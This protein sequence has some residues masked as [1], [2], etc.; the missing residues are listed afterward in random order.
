ML[1]AN[2]LGDVHLLSGRSAGRTQKKVEA[3]EGDSMDD[4]LK[5]YLDQMS[6]KISASMEQ[7]ESRIMSALR[8]FGA[9][10]DAVPAK[11]EG[12]GSEPNSDAARIE[13]GH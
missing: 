12:E 1:T 6:A 4:E 7:L 3:K 13:A 5:R 8:S 11:S 10:S 9:R 2:S